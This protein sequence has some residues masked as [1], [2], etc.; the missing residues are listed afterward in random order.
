[1]TAKVPWKLVCPTVPLSNG[2]EIPI[3]GLGTSHHGGYSHRAVVYALQEC[4]IRHIDTAK[5]YGCESQLAEAIQ[6]SG[7]Q[8]EELWLTTKLWPG[9]YGYQTAKQACLDSCRR[10][11]VKYLDLYLMHWPDCMSPGRSNREVRAETWRALEELHDKGGV[12]PLP[13]ATGAGG[14]LSAAGHCVRGLL[15]SGQRRCSHTSHHHPAGKQ[16]WPHPLPDLH[17]LEHTEW[18]GH[19]SQVNQREKDLGELSSI[20][21]LTPRRRYEFDQRAGC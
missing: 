4:G 3:L 13:A 14:L 18:S 19:N 2:L 1:M 10:L 6:E 9:D 20:W 7:V 12:S 16:A 5:R 15:S 21:V 17:P 11:G 8:R